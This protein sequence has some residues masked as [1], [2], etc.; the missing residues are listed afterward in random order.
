[1]PNDWQRD[2][3]DEGRV[4]TAE[5]KKF[6]MVTVYTPNAK[7]D[8]SRGWICVQALGSGIP[9]LLQAVRAGK[10]YFL[11][12]ISSVAT[13]NRSRQYRCARTACSR[14]ECRIPML[15]AQIHRLRSS[16]AFGVYTVTMW[17]LSKSG[18]ETR[19][20]SALSRCS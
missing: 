10:A 2:S 1:L 18:R 4:I 9:G 14:P 15:G 5:S 8:L 11:I 7:D 19:P 16:L 13:P 17:N 12:A 3:A 20:S 6:H